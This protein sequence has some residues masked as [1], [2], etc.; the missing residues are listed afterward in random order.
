MAVVVAL[1]VIYSQLAIFFKLF[2]NGLH[3]LCGLPAIHTVWQT[4]GGHKT[5]AVLGCYGSCGCSG[6]NLFSA[7]NL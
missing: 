1:V 6:C 7:S 5:S 4:E 3:G 2:K